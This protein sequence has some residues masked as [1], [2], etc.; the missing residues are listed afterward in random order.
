[1]LKFHKKRNKKKINFNNLL[2]LNLIKFR[3][4]IKM[5]IFKKASIERE[6]ADEGLI[7]ELTLW[8]AEKGFNFS[9]RKIEKEI[10]IRGHHHTHPTN[11]FRHCIVLF[12]SK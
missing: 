1:M 11:T 6:S 10:Y 2:E 9:V 4:M 7:N 5:C 3:V 12:F 8:S